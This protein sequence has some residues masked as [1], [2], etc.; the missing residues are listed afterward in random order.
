L[1][2]RLT[3]NAVF[4]P[5]WGSTTSVANA[6][7]ATAAVALPKNCNAVILTNTSATA[8]AHVAVTY[9]SSEGGALPTGDAPTTSSGLPILPN[10]QVAVYVGIGP[11]VIRTI[12]TAADGNIIITPA[13]VS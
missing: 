3:S 4:S 5:A 10:Q 13:N 2:D 9:Y 7:T 11:S 6:I 1:E 8:R 12:A